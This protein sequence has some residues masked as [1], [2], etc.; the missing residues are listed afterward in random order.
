M[1]DSEPEDTEADLCLTDAGCEQECRVEAGA[2]VCY[3]S[4]GFEMVDG[5]CSELVAYQVLNNGSC[6]VHTTI[7]T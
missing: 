3:C 2:P 7:G 6:N 5:Q 1:S 4:P